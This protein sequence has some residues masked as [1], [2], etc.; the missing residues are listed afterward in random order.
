MLKPILALVQWKPSE[1]FEWSLWPTGS[2][3][4]AVSFEP[5][6]SL[7][8]VAAT[9]TIVSW[10]DT[11]IVA[12]LPTVGA[13]EYQVQVEMHGAGKGPIETPIE[14]PIGN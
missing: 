14:T 8:G 1:S 13:G 9:A 7:A 3:T 4:A 6:V 10:T 12:T 5:T 2:P 11:Q